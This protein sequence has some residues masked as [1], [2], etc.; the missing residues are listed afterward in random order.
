MNDDLRC[1]GIYAIRHSASGKVYVGQS[2]NVRKRIQEHSLL[3]KGCTYLRNALKRYGWEA[4]EIVILERVDDL[5]LLNEREQYWIDTLHACDHEL[6]YNLNPTAGSRRGAKHSPETKAKMSARNVSDETKAKLRAA[7]LGKK[8]D[9]SVRAKMSASGKGK[10]HSPEHV[11]KVAAA[12]RGRTA[13]AEEKA[14][15]RAKGL[16]IHPSL[17]TRAK[18]SAA[19]LAR[20][21]TVERTAIL[22]EYI[23]SHPRARWQDVINDTGMS[24]TAVR[25]ILNGLGWHKQQRGCWAQV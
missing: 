5:A 8:C 10:K 7:N 22:L 13:T 15:N 20:H 23:K 25:H 4:F 6:G 21:H 16:G 12:T 14:K 17:E 1:A 3:R 19:H 11:E 9:E 2:Q 18:M 24:D